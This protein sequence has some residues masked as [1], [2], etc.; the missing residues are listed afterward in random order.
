MEPTNDFHTS[1]E[2]AA[3]EEEAQK[4]TTGDR[5]QDVKDI[6]FAARDYF[7]QDRAETAIEA[8][9]NP[10]YFDERRAGVR[11]QILSMFG[12]SGLTVKGDVTEAAKH[13][14]DWVFGE[15]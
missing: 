3:F 15:K 12:P 9:V 7:T 14:E 10:G 13:L 5:K 4:I 6:W 2:E 8:G 1:D 11:L